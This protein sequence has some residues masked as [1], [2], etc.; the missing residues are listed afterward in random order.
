MQSVHVFG[1]RH[2]SSDKYAFNVLLNGMRY[3][4]CVGLPHRVPS[5]RELI[6]HTQQ[7]MQTALIKKKLEEQRENYRKRQEMQRFVS[8]CL[9][10]ELNFNPV[11]FL[12]ADP[13]PPT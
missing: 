3:L 12:P 8:L 4:K 1:W 9:G 11:V 2:Q 10:G 5:P 6:A 7:I 13:I